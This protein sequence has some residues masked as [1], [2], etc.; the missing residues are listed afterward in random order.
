M[1]LFGTLFALASQPAKEQNDPREQFEALK[2]KYETAL[3]EADTQHIL[4]QSIHLMDGKLVIKGMAPS[5]EARTVFWHKVKAADPDAQE[6]IAD[7][8]VVG[9]KGNPAL[10]GKTYTVRSGDT[11]SKISKEFYGD[12]SKY[13]KIYYANQDQLENPRNIQ[14]GQRLIIPYE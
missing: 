9:N 11:L 5:E 7:I 12:A 8:D 3:K 1:S 2:L 4:F 6:V 13:V 14:A 10:H